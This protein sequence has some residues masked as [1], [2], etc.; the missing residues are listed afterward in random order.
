M[1]E[2]DFS[3]VILAAGKG[4][5]MKS[6]LPKI[7]H[8]VAGM[9][10]INRVIEGVK[11]AGAKEV[12]VVLGY[13]ES[14]VKRVIEPLGVNCFKQE[15][16]LGTADAVKSANIEDI[17][18]DVLIIN[19]DHPLIVKSDIIKMYDDFKSSKSDLQVTT[20]K[21]KNPKEFGRIVRH[22]GEIR[23]IVE[24]KD[25]S[26]ETL[27]I[28]EVNTGIYFLK[29]QVLQELL[30]EIKSDNSQN[31]YYI[32][33]LVSMCLESQLKVSTSS[34]SRSV[35]FGVNS[36]IELSKA[37]KYIYNRN[38]KR[39]MEEG[40]TIVD[41]QNTYIEDGVKIGESS[42]IFPGVYL[43]GT[44]RIGKYCVIEQ[45]SFLN[46]MILHDGVII[47]AMSHLEASVIKSKST[48]G[49]Y[50][51]IRPETLVEEGAH[52]G[53]FVELKKTTFGKGSKAGHLA[54]LGDAEIGEDVNIGCGT[55]TCN[56]DV[57]RKK[58]KTIIGDGVF[59]GSDSQLVAPVE[60]GANANIASGSTIT[61][62]IP[63][64]GF[65]IARGRQITKENYVPRKMRE[66]KES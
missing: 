49:P 32:T 41:S 20:V 65:A 37:S 13:G 38:A 61:K 7:L 60:V 45:N 12:R 58:Y 31:E 48:I 25:A 35:S 55:I 42:V 51:R 29:S 17:E 8:P 9:P 53:N 30:P 46:N 24:A 57:D 19:G 43:K 39:V 33:D 11:S 10:M 44:S 5:R 56:Y 16:Q 64:N 22:K 40:A 3:V 47:R 63:D 23:A 34:C 59:V 26:H 62:N 66:N 18:G 6:S 28:N 27:Q 54:Y 15:S 14:L 52:I 36:Q 21:L 1:K 50:A 4:T 2:R